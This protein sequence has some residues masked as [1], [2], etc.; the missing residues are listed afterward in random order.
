MDISIKQISEGGTFMTNYDK[1]V[2]EKCH[3]VNAVEERTEK[4]T[5]LSNATATI[6][7]VT[8]NGTIFI[9]VFDNDFGIEAPLAQ[10]RTP[11]AFYHKDERAEVSQTALVRGN[12]IIE[13]MP[14]THGGFEDGKISMFMISK[15]KG[16]TIA[17]IIVNPKNTDEY[18][19]RI[20]FA[21]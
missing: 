19:Y 5:I 12:E 18:Y 17:F 10:F 21:Q 14:I 9:Q 1:V 4:T 3:Y 6:M 8:N 7:R 11:S 13:E 16:K 15:Q 2:V 20:M